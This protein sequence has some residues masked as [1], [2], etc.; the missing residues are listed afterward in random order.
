MWHFQNRRHQPWERMHGPQIETCFNF[1][2]NSVKLC[3]LYPGSCN[4][5][6]SEFQFFAHS[7]GSGMNKLRFKISSN[8]PLISVR[9]VS[10]CASCTRCLVISKGSYELYRIRHIANKHFCYH[11][12]KTSPQVTQKWITM[13]RIPEKIKNTDSYPVIHN[14]RVHHPKFNV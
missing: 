7:K 12:L 9:I 1:C 2:E 14:T 3:V 10:N 5:R 6:I 13:N 8:A 11:L 4:Y